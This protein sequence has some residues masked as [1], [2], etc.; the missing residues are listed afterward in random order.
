M[1]VTLPTSPPLSGAHAVPELGVTAARTDAGRVVQTLRGD[2]PLYHVHLAWQVETDADLD[3]LLSWLYTH[4]GEE[5][6]CQV[7]GVTYVVRITS[8]DPLERTVSGP[9]HGSLVIDAIGYRIDD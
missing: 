5:I 7:R 8:S 9:V 3:S 1:P 4:R 2:A 6:E